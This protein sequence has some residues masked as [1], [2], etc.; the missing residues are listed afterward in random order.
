MD[1]KDDVQALKNIRNR[2]KNDILSI[3][4]LIS[5]A[6]MSGKGDSKFVKGHVPHWGLLRMSI[7]IAESIGALL[8]DNKSTV[9]NLTDIFE[10][11]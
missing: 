1:K 2:V 11:E 10:K 9:Q 3:I 8:Y 7:P 6:F 5:S 4:D